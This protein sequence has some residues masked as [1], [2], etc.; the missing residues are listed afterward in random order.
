MED[1]EL[2][3]IEDSFHLAKELAYIEMRLME[4]SFH[5]GLLMNR[6][7]LTVILPFKSFAF[8]SRTGLRLTSRCE[9]ETWSD[10]LL[11]AIPLL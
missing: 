6:S 8:S 10:A 1:D 2:L 7:V 5:I 11:L 4:Y 9:T 3:V